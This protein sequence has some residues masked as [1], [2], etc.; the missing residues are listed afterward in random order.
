MHRSVRTSSAQSRSRAQKWAL[1]FI[2]CIVAFILLRVGLRT[3]RASLLVRREPL[4]VALST[5]PTTLLYIP[6][7]GEPT[8][9]SIPSDTYVQVPFGFGYYRI[10]A[11]SKLGDLQ[12]RPELLA[13]TIEN[14]LGVPINYWVALDDSNT[15][16][17]FTSF[18]FIF[19]P[20]PTNLGVIDRALL[21]WRM[22]RTPAEKLV[23]MDLMDTNGLVRRELVDGTTVYEPDFGSIDRFLEH[24]FEQ[25]Q[26][27]DEQLNIT[28]R[29][30]S[31]TAGVGQLV[32][33]L[34]TRSG[35]KVVTVGNSDEQEPC[36]LKGSENLASTQT[37]RFIT[38]TFP[39]V[40]VAASDVVE[41]LEL[42]VG[43]VYAKHI[44]SNNE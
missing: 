30:A 26:L 2:G 6:V 16:Q 20:P 1:V 14:L 8:S 42:V 12:K 36:T 29:N 22:M 21:W 9:I 11:V 27:R 31:T 41:D 33:R 25:S 39:C 28:V 19:Y 4:A 43:S 10:G 37:V 3:I 15:I 13:K 32:A 44:T 34:L 7:E 23:L 24:V 5:N 18:R 40:F 38:S 17:L 35:I